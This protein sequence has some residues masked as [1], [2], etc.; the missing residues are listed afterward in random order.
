M[1]C[2]KRGTMFERVV[3][4]WLLQFAVGVGIGVTMVF[5]EVRPLVL[6]LAGIPAFV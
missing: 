2:F 3:L 4:N 1:A 5:V 6:V